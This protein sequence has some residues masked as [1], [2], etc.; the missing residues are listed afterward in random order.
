[1]QPSPITILP[2]RVALL[3]E[4]ERRAFERIF[5]LEVATGLAEIPAELQPWVLNQFGDLA[6]V[7]QQ[8]IV[9]LVNRLTLEGATF[10]PVRARRPAHS[11]GGDAELEAR[12][13]AAL[14]G[15]DL[16]RAPLT[17]T[18]YDPFG[19]IRGDYSVTATNIAKIDGWHGLVLFDEPHPLRFGRAQLRDYLDVAGRWFAAAHA[20]DPAACYPLIAWNC[21]PKSG[22]TI[23]HGH[24]QLLLARGMPYP[25]VEC[26][27]RVAERYQAEAGAP[28]LDDLYAVHAGLGL[29]VPA[30]RGTRACTHLTPLRNR[31]ILV[32]ADA[33]AN[34]DTLLAL[35]DA[36]YTALRG[37]I[38]G[39]GMRSFNVA[40][41]LQPLGEAGAQATLP[42]FARIA[43]RGDALASSNDWGAME[44]YAMGC[45]TADP[46]DVA[47]LLNGNAIHTDAEPL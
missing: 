36:L 30:A 25:R 24:M 14:A 9:K 37:L 17:H 8:T 10:S 16:F 28:Y 42:A 26:W 15:P 23:T 29:A 3:P 35:A 20:L 7:R 21:L 1:M 22:A 6:A 5:A 13:A 19:R 47:A 27:R 32:I 38:D 2:E 40:I 18:T 43:D 45:I 39:Q 4:P 31:E 46:F 34:A 41:A 11:A 44:L 12:I 33:A